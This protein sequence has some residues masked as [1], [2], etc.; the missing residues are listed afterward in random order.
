MNRFVAVL[1]ALACF[2]T[3]A[4]SNSIMG[5][6]TWFWLIIAIG[7]FVVLSQFV[8]KLAGAG[9]GIALL[10]AIISI[11][12]VLLGLVAATIGGSFRL[13]N[14]EALLLFLFVLIAVFGFTLAILHKKSLHTLRA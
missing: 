8:P 3:S 12:A 4:Q 10:L 7:A 9:A 2:A 13:E 1:F 6:G 5:A 11:C 14:A